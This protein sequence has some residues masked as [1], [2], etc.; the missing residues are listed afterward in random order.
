MRIGILVTSNDTSQFARRHDDDGIKF[1]QLLAPLRPDWDYHILPVWQDVFPKS[2][3]DFDG[4]IVTGSPASVH[5]QHAWVARLLGLIRDA[6]AARI[7]LFGACFGHQAIALALGGQVETWGKGWG[8][9]VVE[10]DFQ[11]ARDWMEPFQGKMRLYAAHGEQVI[12]LPDGAELIGSD[13]FC[14]NAAFAIGS[15]VFTTEYHPEMTDHF[16]AELVEF[17]DGKL[18][19]RTIEQAADSLARGQEG[20][21]FARW[22]VQ[23]F[24]AGATSD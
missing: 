14:Q 24:E 19:Q 16:M 11:P 22:I 12:R 2:L 9:G 1:R 20:S 17:L 13:A 3:S 6:F 10:T 21:A 23:F 8:L 5:D 15:Q 18:D 4:Y 7:P